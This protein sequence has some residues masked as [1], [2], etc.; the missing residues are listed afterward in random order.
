MVFAVQYAVRSLLPMSCKQRT[1]ASRRWPRQAT[2]TWS[3]LPA[4]QRPGA[5][6]KEEFMHRDAD[7]AGLS[8]I[9]RPASYRWMQL[10][11]AIV[12][13]AMIANLQYGWT[14]FLKPIADEC[15]CT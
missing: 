12:C 3:W 2:P 5:R 9:S 15:G 14:L 4:R 13:M 8:A 1:L 7:A 10:V 11:M 6:T